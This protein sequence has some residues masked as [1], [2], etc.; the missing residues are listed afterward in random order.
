[1]SDEQLDIFYDKYLTLKLQLVNDGGIIP[2]QISYKV[3]HIITMKLINK[4]LENANKQSIEYLTDF[5]KIDKTLIVNDQTRKIV[6]EMDAEICDN[7]GK[8]EIGT[9]KGIKRYNR[10]LL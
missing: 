10:D 5:I 3:K 6:E 4:I 9:K 7:F 1:M 2:D 8:T